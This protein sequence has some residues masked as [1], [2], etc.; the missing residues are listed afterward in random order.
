M[1]ILKRSF[2]GVVV[3]T[4]VFSLI[5]CSSN[6]V[7]NA[8]GVINYDANTD[9]KDTEKQLSQALDMP[10]NLLAPKPK[11]GSSRF[12]EALAKNSANPENG[13]Q[14]IP[15]YRSDKVKIGHNL[16]E[17][18]LEV[19]GL[20]SKQVWDGVQSFLVSLG[21]EIKESRKD[22]GFI[23]TK[24][25]P[26]K[27]LAP[28]DAQGPL[29]KL[30]N[31]WHEEVATGVYD[32]LVARV[33]YDKTTKVTKVYFYHY[34]VVDGN[35]ADDDDVSGSSLGSGWRIKPFNPMIESEV[36]YQAM[37][38]FGAASG[39]AL[40]QV[41]ATRSLIEMDDGSSEL[42][43]LEVDASRD[44]TWSY[45]VALIYRAGWSVDEMDKANFV[46]KVKLPD[47]VRDIS[48]FSD[49][50][51]FWGDAK[52]GLPQVVSF[53]LENKVNAV[54]HFT[55]LTVRS[56]EDDLPFKPEEQ[57]HIFKSLGL[58]AK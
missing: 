52:L 48:S 20:P 22:I 36:L 56:T 25:I 46:V 28:I 4:F 16:S 13:F 38:F 8:E 57:E 19:S 45:L 39:T 14:F 31:S 18:W 53:K 9:Y 44:E 33:I 40:K 35:E 47:S 26:R 27:E 23:K 54:K 5:G 17:R 30:L 41:E 7:K 24:F 11:R 3:S 10:P 12:D 49:K 29:T 1:K 43:G 21:F 50:L 32:R 6:G 37:I 2:V 15:T 58:L 51:A 42:N 34:M 55:L